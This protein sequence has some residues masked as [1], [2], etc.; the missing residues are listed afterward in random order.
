MHARS[1]TGMEAELGE[2]RL[3]GRR[4]IVS[5]WLLVISTGFM[6]AFENMHEVHQSTRFESVETLISID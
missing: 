1:E 3:T 4:V 5:I 6:P 2:N